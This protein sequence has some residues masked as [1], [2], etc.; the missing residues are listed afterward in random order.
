MKF[1][2]HSIIPQYHS[3][4]IYTLDIYIYQYKYRWYCITKTY[5]VD[6]IRSRFNNFHRTLNLPIEPRL[7]N[8]Q[9]S[10]KYYIS[11]FVLSLSIA[12][13]QHSDLHT[14]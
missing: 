11:L 7:N 13:M 4:I 10:I 6:T 8:N 1:I 5:V 2:N 12:M 3:Y 9:D 14:C